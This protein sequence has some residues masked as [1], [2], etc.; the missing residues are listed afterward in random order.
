[1]NPGSLRA[2]GLEAFDLLQFHVWSDEW[3]GRGD[4]LETIEDLT[5]S[6]GTSSRP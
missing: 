5:C 4:W 3:M 6:A 1:V 2:S